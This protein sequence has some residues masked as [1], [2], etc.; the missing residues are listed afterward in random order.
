[1]FMQPNDHV[2]IDTRSIV[3]AQT[4]KGRPFLGMKQNFAFYFVPCR[5]M[6]SYSKALFTGLKPKNTLISS[7]LSNNAAQTAATKPVKA[8]VF[9]PYQVF[10]RF[11][12][13]PDESGNIPDMSTYTTN[14]ANQGT[15]IFG[16]AVDSPSTPT[17]FNEDPGFFGGKNSRPNGRQSGNDDVLA[18]AKPAS[19]VPTGSFNDVQPEIGN[20]PFGKYL[21]Q[22]SPF[23][24]ALGYPLLPSYVRF[25]DLFRYGAMPYIGESI[26][27]NEFN[28]SMFA[29]EANLFYFLAY[30]KIYQDHFLDSNFEN[31]NPLSYNVDDLFST[32]S[33]QS[34]FDLK[35]DIKSL[36]RALDIF[37]PRYVKYNKDLLSN[38]HPSPLF[39][40]DVSQTIKSFVGSDTVWSGNNTSIVKDSP[41]FVS[42]ANLRNLFAFDKMQQISSR[43][44]KTY[45]G[46]MLAHYGVNVADD[47]TESIYCGGFQKVLEV[48]PVIATSDGQAA[49]S[50]TNFGQQG[51]YIDSGQ[52]GH[53]NF[54]AK[55]HGVLMCVSWFS[56]ASLYDS[57]GIDAFNVKFARE[58]YFVPEMEDLGMQPIDYSRLLPPWASLS[59]YRLPDMSG[60]VEE[61]YS[62]HQSDVKAAYDKLYRNSRL[63]E[64]GRALGN[65]SSKF[66]AEKVYGWQ[67]RYHEY[68]SGADYIHGEFKTGRSMQVLTLHRPTP[69]N[70]QL[71]VGMIKGRDFPNK[72][73]NGVPAGFLFV[74]PACTN[75]VVEVNYDGTEKT[76]PFRI[77]TEFN[78]SYISDMSVSGMPKV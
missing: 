77:S 22:K 13:A 55:E 37:S 3:Q 76:D 23:Y 12:G 43:A 73:F 38:I 10:A 72:N 48:N 57:D 45:K 74:D 52:S 29:Y 19:G 67:P 75:E 66:P 33:M 54:D 53:V 70:Y 32:D 47:M 24:D 5:L 68:K 59:D 8:P 7:L 26:N 50:S 40:D 63:S 6:Y 4:L 64:H 46:Q 30:Q 51:S 34:K 27:V 1:M 62:K 25:C 41:G 60:A 42:A 14:S 20:S 56:P 65:N 36:D 61:Y 18:S 69:F 2:S 21:V 17:G 15:K 28:A 16:G 78:V 58:D 44:P 49:D 39:I 71:G 31:V 9:K 11:A 35:V